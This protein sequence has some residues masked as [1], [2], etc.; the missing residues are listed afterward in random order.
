MLDLRYE[1]KMECVSQGH[2]SNSN[3]RFSAIKCLSL[4][5]GSVIKLRIEF[6]GHKMRQGDMFI[7]Y[8]LMSSVLRALVVNHV[9][10][11]GRGRC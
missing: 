8:L 3:S 2:H 4:S 6:G 7:Y 10:D 5:L 1:Q 9:S 11:H